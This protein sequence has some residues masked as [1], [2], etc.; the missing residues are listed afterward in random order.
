MLHHLKI[1]FKKMRPK[2]TFFFRSMS[3]DPTKPRKKL[4]DQQTP[5]KKNSS[6]QLPLLFPSKFRLFQ[7]WLLYLCD[8]FYYPRSIPI[9]APFCSHG[10]DRLDLW[11][12]CTLDLFEVGKK[13][14]KPPPEKWR[15]V[16]SGKLKGGKIFCRRTPLSNMGENATWDGLMFSTQVF[17]V[18]LFFFEKNP[19]HFLVFFCL[20]ICCGIGK[21]KLNGFSWWMD[22]AR[23]MLAFVKDFCSISLTRNLFYRCFFSQRSKLTSHGSLKVWVAGRI[24]I[25]SPKMKGIGTTWWYPIRISKPPVPQTTNPLTITPFLLP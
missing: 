13:P 18:V 17:W 12:L 8:G 15:H 4:T 11:K 22:L 7:A 24:P 3:L 16:G 23:Y 20:H 1:H 21:S 2:K 6:T 25:G 10:T 19:Y 14:S 5:P 9:V